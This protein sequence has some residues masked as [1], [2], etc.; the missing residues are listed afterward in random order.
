M[1]EPITMTKISPPE[2]RRVYH[3]ANGEKVELMNVVGV[4]VRPSGTHR[5]ETADGRKWI[6]PAGWLAIELDMEAWTL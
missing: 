2:K 3:F 5:L 6:V 4:C 1:S